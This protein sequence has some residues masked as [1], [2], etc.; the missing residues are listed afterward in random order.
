ML[1]VDISGYI[2]RD[3]ERRDL[4]R[5]YPQVNFVFGALES[6]RHSACYSSFI[7]FVPAS[8]RRRRSKIAGVA[9]AV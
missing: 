8:A 2:F 3:R 4:H 9:L 6:R 7:G 5:L 1:K